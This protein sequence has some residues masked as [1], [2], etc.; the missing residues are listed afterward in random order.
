M[1][2]PAVY[3]AGMRK[4]PVPAAARKPR[5][6]YHHGHLRQA[7][8]DQAVRTIRSR[9]VE[10]LT[11][12]E[13][14]QDLRVSRTALYRHFADKQA[15]LAA[16]AAEG[17]RTFRQALEQA[18]TPSAHD[19]AGFVA[20]GH[21][22]VAFAR[23]HPSYYRVMFGGFVA[24][25]ECDPGLAEVADSAFGVLVGA[26]AEM[27]AAGV[28]EAGDPEALAVFVWSAVHGLAL[29]VID[30]QLARPG[31]DVAEVIDLT[32]AQVWRGI[33]AYTRRD[34][35]PAS[36]APGPV[37]VGAAGGDSSAATVNPGVPGTP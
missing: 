28:V 11:L 19:R 22:Y 31:V 6:A 24:K 8:V 18:W 3:D 20:M 9:G 21:A 7:L 32:M 30:G 25:V 5:H 37:S 10:G 2:T 34:Q 29:L 36:G 13:V 23:E 1:S 4:V 26:I 15:L 12:R 17:F 33:A 16:V 14:G 35:A 27:Q